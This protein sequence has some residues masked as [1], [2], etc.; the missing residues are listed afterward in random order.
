VSQFGPGPQIYKVGDYVLTPKR[1][2]GKVVGAYREREPQHDEAYW[3]YDLNCWWTSGDEY[4]QWVY[5]IEVT[6]RGEKQVEPWPEDML[7]V[8]GLLDIIVA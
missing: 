3:D 7:E 4:I 6:V 1:Q 8:A 5:K 2:P